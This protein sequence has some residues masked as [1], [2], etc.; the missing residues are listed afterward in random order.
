MDM[1][2]P[3]GQDEHALRP[4]LAENEPGPH[5]AQ[6]VTPSVEAYSPAGQGVQTPGASEYWPTGQARQA[7][8]LDE[9]PML[10][11]H[12]FSRVA[13]SSGDLEFAGQAVHAVEPFP[14]AYVSWAQIAHDVPAG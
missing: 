11:E 8:P 4:L 3:A 10:Q 1:A 5:S 14:V 9:N 6:V 7:L 12:W 2:E 13:P